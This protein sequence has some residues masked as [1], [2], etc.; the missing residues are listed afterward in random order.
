MYELHVCSYTYIYVVTSPILFTY[1]N[2]TVA[3]SRLLWVHDQL[4]TR[5]RAVFQTVQAGR[6]S[7]QTAREKLHSVGLQSNK[8]INRP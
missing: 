3:S 6:H 7:A 2:F 5:N 4:N 8:A 1:V